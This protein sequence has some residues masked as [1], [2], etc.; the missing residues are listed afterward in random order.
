M[1]RYGERLAT[2]GGPSAR[3]C[4]PGLSPIVSAF[5]LFYVHLLICERKLNLNIQ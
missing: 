3:V 2:A 4:S 1:L 5:Q